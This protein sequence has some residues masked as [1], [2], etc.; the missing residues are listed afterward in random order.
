MKQ[1]YFLLLVLLFSSN[2][3]TQTLSSSPT[4]S[5]SNNTGFTDNIA[6]DGEGG[7]T[8]ITDIN[9]QA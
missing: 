2:I 3:F 6:E 8:N 4:I 5:F 7:S 1:I 9:I